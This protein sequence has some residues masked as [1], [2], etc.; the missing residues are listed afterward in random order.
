[1]SETLAKFERFMND[2]EAGEL[3]ITGVAGTG[4]TTEL[5]S[6]LSWCIDNKIPAV[7]TAYTHKAC[8]VLSTKLPKQAIICT[9]HSFLKKRPTVNDKALKIEHVDGNAQLGVPD[10]VKVLFIDEFSMVG[11]KDFVSINDLQYDEEGNLRTK[12]VYIGD[13]NQ[14]PPVKDA[15]A[16]NPKGPHWIK[17]TKIYRQANDNPLIDTLISLNSYINGDEPKPLEEHATFKRGRDIVELYKA[18]KTSKIILAYTNNRV[19]ELNGKIQGYYQPKQSDTLWTPTLRSLHTL[20][21]CE[22]NTDSIIGIRGDIIELGSKYKTLETLHEIEDVKFYTIEDLEGNQS[23]RAAIFGHDTFLQKQQSLAKRA[24]AVNTEIKE[25]FQVED[26]TAWAKQNWST[27]LA[28]KR[29]RAWKHY[30]AFKDNVICLD[31]AHAMTVHKSQG[32]T[33]ENV[34]LDIEDMGKCAKSDYTMY[35]KLLYVAISRA[36]KAVYTN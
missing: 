11:E 25:K 35:L 4:K 9:L 27:E 33:Y 34:F 5:G 21:S 13:P 23:Q 28:K 8:G 19:E 15:V 7:T 29:A 26:P 22:A 20:I 16:V 24:V 3:Y 1:M 32:S 2:R 36:S 18:C 14:L 12:V 31:F 6:L 30:L 17:L 10:E